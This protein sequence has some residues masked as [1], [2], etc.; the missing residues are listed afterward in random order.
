MFTQSQRKGDSRSQWS[1]ALQSLIQKLV[2]TVTGTHCLLSLK[3]L[4]KIS[5]R[6]QTTDPHRTNDFY[7]LLY[8]NYVL[9]QNQKKTTLALER[10]LLC[11]LENAITAGTEMDIH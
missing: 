10:I 3:K 11:I 7:C 5:Q 1:Q 6:D 9:M 2:G 8:S 4:K